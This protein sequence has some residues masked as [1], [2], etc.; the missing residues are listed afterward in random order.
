MAQGVLIFAEVAGGN[1][2]SIAKEMLGAGRRLADAL[3][4]PLQAAV[5][6]HGVEDIAQEVIYHGADSV[7]VVDN[8]ALAQYQ[9]ASYTK[10][11]AALVQHIEP[12]ILL[13]G[14]SDN[15]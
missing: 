12:N 9:T 15:G 10:A 4:E 2:A 8:P 1:L 3:G 14:I 6:G 13:V 11:M 5:L 7:Y